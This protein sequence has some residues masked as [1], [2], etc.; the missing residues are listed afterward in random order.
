MPLATLLRRAAGLGMVLATMLACALLEPPQVIIP[1]PI[2]TAPPLSQTMV[3][4]GEIVTDPVSDVVPNMDP[5]IETLVNAVS[6]QQLIS[7]VQTLESFGTRNSFSDAARPDWGVGAARQWI[8]DEF[9]RVGQSS[10]GRMEVRFED[11]P[12]TVGEFSA[13]QQNV[14]ATLTGTTNP[15]DVI[16]LMAHYDTRPANPLDGVS[17]APGANDNGAG[18]ALLIESARLLSARPWNQTIIFV[19]MAAEEQGT[20]GAK[21]FVQNAILNNLNVLAAVNYDGVGGNYGIPQ[22]IRLFAPDLLQSPSGELGRYVDFVGGMYVPAFPINVE[23]AM[24]REERWGDHREFIFAGMPAVRLTQSLEDPVYLNSTLDTWSALDF[25]YLVQVVK[26]NVAVAG[27]MA[28]GPPRPQAPLITQMAGA[29]TYLL[30]WEVS[31]LAAGYAISFRPLDFP[32]FPAFRFVSAGQ[33]GNVALTG[34]DASR[35]HAVSIA[36]ISATGRLGPFS[37]EVMWGGGE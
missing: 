33:A 9:T 1:T 5:D 14:V 10:N 7:Y 24:D 19:A 17:R 3:S 22:T 30:T 4:S 8:F 15:N 28:G 29:N 11:F 34:L 2:P 26:L 12:L 16:V 27:N 37:A 21:N 36:G 31:P 23:N 18:V 6:K 20:F 13:P 32:S 35:P 25:D